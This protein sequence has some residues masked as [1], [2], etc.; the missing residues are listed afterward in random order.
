M[1]LGAADPQRRAMVEACRDDLAPLAA[2]L[3]A[4]ARRRVGEGAFLGHIAYGCLV[5]RVA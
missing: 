2:A 4:E 5:A 1:E 3:E